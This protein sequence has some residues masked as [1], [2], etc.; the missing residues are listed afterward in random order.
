MNKALSIFGARRVILKIGSSLLIK[1]EKFDFS[2][3]ES[4]IDDLLLLRKKK[5]EIL[6]VASGAVSLGKNYL[7]IK[8]N[9]I[10]I[11][12]KQACAACGQVILMNNFMKS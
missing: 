9:K 5:I 12:E 1:N 4:L 3:F 8:R 6:I 11:N 10:K 7:G 2:W